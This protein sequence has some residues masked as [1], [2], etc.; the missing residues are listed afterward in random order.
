MSEPDTPSK[1]APPETRSDSARVMLIARITGIVLTL[2]SLALVFELI[3]QGT[4]FWESS[5][6]GP[7][8]L[9]GILAI[10][11]AVLGVLFAL[12][13][14]GGMRELLAMPSNEEEV[15]SFSN[16]IKFCLLIVALI[17]AFPVLGGVLALGAFVALEMLWV[18]RRPVFQALVVA[19]V[20]TAAT[21]LIFVEILS[22]P[23]PR[24]LLAG[25]M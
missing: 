9:P 19:L 23:L 14:D 10:A 25:L 12:D 15:A 5:G 16:S 20:S 11:L 7:G 4:T 3:S 17:L 8:F 22:V 21:W 1:Q 18:E 13:V 2:I 6:P 24:G